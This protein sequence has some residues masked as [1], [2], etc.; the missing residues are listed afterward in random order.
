MVVECLHALR[1]TRA[2][3]HAAL[4][5]HE[6]TAARR[7]ETDDTGTVLGVLPAA[8][9]TFVTKG[10]SIERL[11]AAAVRDLLAHIV[12]DFHVAC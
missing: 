5:G 2:E 11:I 4:D 9:T 1:T 10:W 7:R 12:C 6:D 3:A 8:S